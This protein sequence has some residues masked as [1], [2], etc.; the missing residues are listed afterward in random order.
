MRGGCRVLVLTPTRELAA[1]IAESFRVYGK[2]ARHHG[3]HR[4]MA[5]SPFRPQVNAMARGVDILVATPGRLIDHLEQ[6]SV[7]LSGT[8]VLVL[9]EADQMLDMG[10]IAPIRKILAQAVASAGRAC[11]SR[12]PCRARSAR[13]P[14][15]CCAIR[16]ACR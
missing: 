13:W 16:C 3:R 7:N 1:Q 8:E 5:A 6:R 14:P 2:H 10:F 4:C 12:R 9:D 11:S 15:R